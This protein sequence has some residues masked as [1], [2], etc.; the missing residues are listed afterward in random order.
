VSWTSAADLR[1]QVQK[2][3]DKGALLRPCVQGA[4]M[5]PRRLWFT[6]LVSDALGAALQTTANKGQA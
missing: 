5:L 6:G 4:V 3:W 2:L 1:A